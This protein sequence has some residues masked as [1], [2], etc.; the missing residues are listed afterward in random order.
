[1]SGNVAEWTSTPF[2]QTQYSF[3]HDLNPD[4]R[5]SAQD[6]DNPKMKRKVIK[7]GSWKDI[8][9][10]IQIAARDYAQQD[11]ASSFIGFRCVKTFE[12]VKEFEN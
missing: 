6:S 4:Y 11:E 5:Y 1:M 9:A 2:E 12:H 7:G 10:F 3:W 8:G